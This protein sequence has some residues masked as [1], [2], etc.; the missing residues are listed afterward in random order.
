MERQRDTGYGR[1]LYKTGIH[2]RCQVLEWTRAQ[3]FRVSQVRLVK[4]LV[5]HCLFFQLVV[6][7]GTQNQLTSAVELEKCEYQITGTTPALCLPLDE[8]EEIPMDDSE[9]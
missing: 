1:V 7:C 3:C 6:S 8:K 4:W 2:R 9:L 5:T